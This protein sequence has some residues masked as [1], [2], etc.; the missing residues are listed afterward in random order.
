M[1]GERERKIEKIE[2]HS[3]KEEAPSQ[4]TFFSNPSISISSF[5]SFCLFQNP[6]GTNLKKQTNKTY[7]CLPLPRSISTGAQYVTPDSKIY[8]E[9]VKMCRF[10]SRNWFSCAK[11]VQLAA[12]G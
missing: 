11:F 12:V 1:S 2:V 4:A 8:C 7:L 10:S 9:K 6:L 5:N 3:I